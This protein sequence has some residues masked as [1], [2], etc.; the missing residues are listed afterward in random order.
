M[1]AKHHGTA[2]NRNE[3]NTGTTNTHSRGEQHRTGG[4]GARSWTG[5]A[6]PGGPTRW[7]APRMWGGALLLILVFFVINALVGIYHWLPARDLPALLVPLPEAAFAA[8][9]VIVVATI[10]RRSLLPASVVVGFLLALVFSFAVGEAF[11]QFVYREH[12][13]MW[14]DAR[15]LPSFLEMVTGSPVLVE[16]GVVVALVAVLL[17]LL[18]AVFSALVHGLGRLALRPGRPVAVAIACVLIAAGALT[19]S[20]VLTADPAGV[21]MIRQLGERGSRYVEE[22]EDEAAED[23]AAEDEAEEGQEPDARS[24]G[25]EPEDASSDYAFPALQDENV[26]I[27]IIESYGHTLFT[28]NDHYELI[29]DVYDRLGSQ[30]EEAGFRS[31]SHF[32]KSPAFGG[33]SW[34]ADATILS[35]TWIG[36]Q[37]AYDEMW[38][39]DTTTLVRRMKEAGYYSVLAAPGMTYLEDGFVDFFPYD[40]VYLQGEFGYEGKHYS[41]GGGLTDQFMLNRVRQWREDGEV[42]NDTDPFFGVYVMV[43][44]HV[45]FNVLPPLIDDWERIGDGEIYHDLARRVFDNDWLRGGEYPEGYTASIEYS[46]SSVVDYLTTF[47]DDETL[48]IIIGD[49]QPR[50]PIAEQSSTFSVPVHMVSKN[51]SLVKRFEAF[52][53]E[54]GFE[55]SQPTPHPTMDEL[56]TMFMEAAGGELSSPAR[57]SSQREMTQGFEVQQRSSTTQR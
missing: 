18:T 15:F 45:P 47:V 41:F 29:A 11:F 2:P 21:M 7:A 17:G 38:E 54:E 31:Y 53:F 33:R 9:V 6:E 50:I 25:P 46:L 42:G 12:F 35:G 55:P 27:F 5:A 44:S 48:A 30:L 22:T 14:R 39:S 57:S 1:A 40:D 4:V 49:H 13:S 34:L 20:R 32:M 16:P 56:A 51:D 24:D 43:S 36:D 23:E 3:T 26:E 10:A 28:R 37:T 19:H 8:A 52:G